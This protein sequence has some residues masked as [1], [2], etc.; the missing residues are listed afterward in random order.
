MMKY[1]L[2]KT[3]ARLL[4]SAFAVLGISQALSAQEM[5]DKV[6]CDSTTIL[7]YYIAAHDYGFQPMAVPAERYE[8]G[9]FKPL[10]EAMMSMEDGM[11]SMATQEA[12]MATEESMMDESMM[13]MLSMAIIE[14]E[15]AECTCLRAEMEAFFAKKFG[16]KYDGMMMDGAMGQPEAA[17]MEAMASLPDW[18]SLPI[19]DALS[20]Q[21]FTLAD[22]AGKTIYVEP[23]ATWCSNCRTQLRNVSEANAQ[24]GDDVVFIALSVETNLSAADLQTYQ[25]QTGYDM[26]FAVATPELLAALVSAF[27]RTVANPPATPHFIIRPDGSLSGLVT[28]F[29]DTASVIASVQAQ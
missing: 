11:G 10:F 5:T 19:T 14:G 13:T 27:G 18:A 8:L 25:A 20:G 12:M 9:Q 2:R 21:S 3:S 29:K 7:L 16:F 22:F 28:G 26:T 23:F 4:A 6:A 24:L 1:T 15:A 17:P